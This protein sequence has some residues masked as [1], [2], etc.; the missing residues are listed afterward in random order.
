MSLLNRFNFVFGGFSWLELAVSLDLSRTRL[1][2]ETNSI[3]KPSKVGF[4][5]IGP[6][7]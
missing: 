7:S 1:N 2:I 5:L 3:L 6:K 4:I